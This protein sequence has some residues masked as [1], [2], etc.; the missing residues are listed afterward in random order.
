MLL[1]LFSI[2]LAQ[3]LWQQHV[4]GGA[5]ENCEPPIGLQVPG[6]G[7]ENVY[8]ECIGEF[9]PTEKYWSKCFAG[10][11]FRRDRWLTDTPETHATAGYA[12]PVQVL[13]SGTRRREPKIGYRPSSSTGVVYR[14][15]DGLLCVPRVRDETDERHDRTTPGI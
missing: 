4:L 15:E 10:R 2:L 3:L 8:N 14:E 5:N 1:L 12:V 11:L 6:S 7:T 9:R 13:P